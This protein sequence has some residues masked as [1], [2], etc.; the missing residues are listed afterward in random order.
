MSRKTNPSK[1]IFWKKHFE[2]QPASGM[3]IKA[4]CHEHGLDFS[5]WCYWRKRFSSL[6]TQ[7]PEAQGPFIPVVMPDFAS[8]VIRL[9]AGLSVQLEIP[10]TVSPEWIAKLLTHLELRNA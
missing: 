9:R 3:S 2:A 8:N 10:A 6:A 5:S 4:Y 7:T 1:H